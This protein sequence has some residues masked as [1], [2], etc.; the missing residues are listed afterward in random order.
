MLRFVMLIIIILSV[1][2]LSIVMVSVRHLVT[3]LNIT[4]IK[5]TVSRINPSLLLNINLQNT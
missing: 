3:G 5:K 2:M 4:S 1:N